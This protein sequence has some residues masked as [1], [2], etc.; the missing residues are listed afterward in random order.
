[1]SAK[2][3]YERWKEIHDNAPMIEC[4]CGCGTLIKS[5]DLYGRDKFY[6]NGHNNRKYMDKNQYQR[7]WNH[8]NKDKRYQSKVSRLN[9]LK[10]EMIEKKGGACQ[11]CECKYNG[12][13]AAIFDFH[14]RNPEHKDIALN[15]KSLNRYS[16]DDIWKELEKCDLLCSN[17]H[18]MLHWHQDI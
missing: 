2:S 5:K 6:E 3:S 16:L 13:N 1:M 9:R 11:D 18:R 7:E 12:K 17:C 14:H 4:A 15:K 8:R 10:A